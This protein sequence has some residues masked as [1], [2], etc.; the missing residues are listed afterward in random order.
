M[1]IRRLW[2]ALGSVL[3]R[4]SL[5]HATRTRTRHVKGVTPR[6]IQ[7][8]KPIF[9]HNTAVGRSTCPIS[10]L[11]S[12]PAAYEMD[13]YPALNT[14]QQLLNLPHSPAQRTSAVSQPIINSHSKSLYQSRSPPST[15][16]QLY[17]IILGSKAEMQPA[18]ASVSPAP[19]TQNDHLCPVWK[20]NH[21]IYVWY[22]RRSS[23]STYPC[24]DT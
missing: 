15:F 3:A 17:V 9:D 18:R 12:L 16:H 11:D 8:C 5:S 19:G 1:E 23:L 7:N 20:L 14:S 13:R 2:R 24:L 21:R 10:R 6:G 4:V 22:P